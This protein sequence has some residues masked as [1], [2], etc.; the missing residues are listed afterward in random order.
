MSEIDPWALPQGGTTTVG[1]GLPNSGYS[2]PRPVQPL[3]STLPMVVLG[4]GV[5]YVLVSIVQIFMFNN[6]IS[7]A[8]QSNAAIAYPSGASGDLL[9][10]AQSSDNNITTVSWIA[11]VVFLGTLFAI[12]AWQASLNTTLGSVGARQAVF[13]RAGYQYFRG[14][15]A[16]SLV[17]SLVLQFANNTDNISTVQDIINHDH[18]FMLYYGARA[19]VGLVL[20]FFAFRLKK[21]SQEGVARLSGAY[22]PM[23]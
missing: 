5:L 9:S 11:L 16:V 3:N 2:A 22:T 19:V 10:Q 20:I 18:Q 6:Q 17:L 12:R 23:S 21:I 7:V 13:K 15:W 1:A 4:F 8:N 14:A